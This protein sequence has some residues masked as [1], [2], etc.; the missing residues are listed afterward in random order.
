MDL[1]L[2]DLVS[3]TLLVGDMGSY[4]DANSAYVRRMGGSHP[5]CRACVQCGGRGDAGRTVIHATG[6]RRKADAVRDLFT[7]SRDV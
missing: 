5:A 3:V 4:A 6:F 2:S 7:L 1:S